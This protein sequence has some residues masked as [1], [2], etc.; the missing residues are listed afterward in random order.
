MKRWKKVSLALLAVLI[1]SQ[2]PFI[3]RRYRLGRLHAAIESL[4][5]QRA[6]AH[7]D[8]YTDYKGVLHVHSMLG[9]HSNGRFEDIVQ[10][11]HANNLA[12]VVMTEHPSAYVNT[13]E[14]TL[15]G[16]HDGV[17]FLNGSEISAPGEV[18]LLV[19][20]G[21]EPP[22]PDSNSF[23]A[24]D[25]I[26]QATREGRLVFVAYPEQVRDWQL[27]GFDGMEVYNL[28]TNSQRVSYSRL[29][30]DGLWSYWSYPEL[31]FAT[32]YEKPAAN[33]KRWD[34]I[35]AGGNRRAVAVAGNDAHANVGLSLRQ[36]TG[37]P[38][39]EL[40]LDPYERSF[41]LVRNHVLLEKGQTLDAESLT[42]A[43]RQ[44]HS[45]IAFDLFGDAGGFRF[46]AETTSEKK[47][48]GDEITLPPGGGVRLT[49]SV[50]VK[51]RLV[52]FKNGQV[53][54]EERDAARKELLVN[55]PGVYRVEIYLD[56]LG[57]PLD[58]APWII[59]NPIYVR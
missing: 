1:L 6:A 4:N 20:P 13:A 44:G 9:G 23:T 47:I 45:F 16:S 29:F 56:Q 43:L 19:V 33:L 49:A 36:L 59:S 34:E 26:T 12:F 53:A 18:R 51:G 57:R 28:Y 42:S 8:A 41:R 2:T 37:Q 54:H 14:A 46:S 21:I 24:Q 58:A 32:I 25:I 48:M 27:S 22:G 5:A 3:Y 10:A 31:L 50:P 38:I 30:F 11:A 40:K 55:E 52:F 15:K 17:L 39:L 7:D 35:N